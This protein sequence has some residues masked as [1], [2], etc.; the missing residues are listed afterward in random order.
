MSTVSYREIQIV[1]S[2]Y[3]DQPLLILNSV[4]PAVLENTDH[5]SVR[6]EEF[7]VSNGV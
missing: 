2:A 3:D 6:F 5:L 1:L 4:M 7:Q